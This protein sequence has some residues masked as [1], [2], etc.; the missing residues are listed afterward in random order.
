MCVEGVEGGGG[1]P[2]AEPS[3]ASETQKSSRER[4]GSERWWVRWVKRGS[5]EEEAA[6]V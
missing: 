5:G 3:S 4:R 6:E 1:G 2:L